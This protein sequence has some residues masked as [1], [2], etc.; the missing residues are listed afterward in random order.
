MYR[1]NINL[2]TDVLASFFLYGDQLRNSEIDY[3]YEWYRL[4]CA[5]EMKPTWKR[6]TKDVAE[7]RPLFLFE[8][9]REYTSI[10][11]VLKH[12]SINNVIEIGI[13]KATRLDYFVLGDRVIVSHFKI[14]RALKKDCLVI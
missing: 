10:A 11:K 14:D 4:T 6:P 3:S 7:R 13:E 9:V 12:T 5:K 8:V 2:V 1:N